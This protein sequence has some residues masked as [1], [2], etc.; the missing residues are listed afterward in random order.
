M[1]DKVDKRI[2]DF[3]QTNGRM[4]NQD[5]ADKVGLSPSPCLRRVRQLED[6]GYIKKYVA[7]LDPKKIGLNMTIVVLVGLNSHDAKLM[8]HFESVV[9]SFQEVVECYVIAG[10]SQ[11]YILKVV[12]P[13]LDEYQAFMLKKL[14]QINGVRNIHSSFVLRS[15]VDKTEL[16]LI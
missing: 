9:K 16:P 12:V 5:L 1:V 10:Q 3:L 7:L 4:N 11:D 13:G 15:V 14:T 8:S 6:E 2:L